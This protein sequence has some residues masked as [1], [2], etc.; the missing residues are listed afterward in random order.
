MCV[1]RLFVWVCTFLFA[2][3]RPENNSNF[4]VVDAQHL[5]GR[6]LHSVRPSVCHNVV[7]MN[8]VKCR[9]AGAGFDLVFSFSCI[10]VCAVYC[11]VWF[12]S[13]HM[14]IHCCHSIWRDIFFGRA[15]GEENKWFVKC[16]FSAFRKQ[17]DRRT[18]QP[19][20]QPTNRRL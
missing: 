18:N 12:R 17:D 13:P 20:R 9:A 10:S 7:I 14:Y 4:F 15:M 3:I 16:N 11:L 5:P 6:F 8:M 2:A 19:T 1:C